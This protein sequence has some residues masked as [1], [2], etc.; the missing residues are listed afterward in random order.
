V[1]KGMILA[2]VYQS[3]MRLRSSIF[4]TFTNPMRHLFLSIFFL[5]LGTSFAFAQDEEAKK[6]T[7]PEPDEKK[8]VDLYKKGTDKKP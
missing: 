2:S 5:I 8:A 3:L 1:E 4:D 6:S 7:C